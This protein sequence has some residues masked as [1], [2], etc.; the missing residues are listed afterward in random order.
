M[1]L[2]DVRGLPCEQYDE[3]SVIDFAIRLRVYR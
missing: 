1:R 3:V 2:G